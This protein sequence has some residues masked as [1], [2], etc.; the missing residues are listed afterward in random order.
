MHT[1][2]RPIHEPGD[3]QGEVPM[4]QRMTRVSAAELGPLTSCFKGRWGLFPLE[5]DW[6]R[7]DWVAWV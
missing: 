3:A 5:G 1:K 2:A 7:W 4:S 6:G